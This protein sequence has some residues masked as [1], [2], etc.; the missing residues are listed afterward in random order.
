[1]RT[2]AAIAILLLSAASATSA[3]LPDG[4]YPIQRI[5]GRPVAPGS[6]HT[7]SYEAGLITAFDGCNVTTG[8]AG[9]ADGAITWTGPVM[10]T[11]GSCDLPE[12]TP[13]FANLVKATKWEIKGGSLLITDDL[14]NTIV[15]ASVPPRQ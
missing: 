6:P 8:G 2:I 15:A 11:M 10:T 3:P 9:T 4:T 13:G 1:M 5:D 7:I 14:G 12:N